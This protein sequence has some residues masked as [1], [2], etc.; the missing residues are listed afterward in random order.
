MPPNFES[1]SASNAIGEGA[2]YART[3]I[4]GPTTDGCVVLQTPCGREVWLEQA[5]QRALLDWLHRQLG[6]TAPVARPV[7]NVAYETCDAYY[8]PGGTYCVLIGD[9]E[10]TGKTAEHCDMNGVRW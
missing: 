4:G 7:P 2:L 3:V 1:F 8:A 6:D 5:D 9:H 10:Y